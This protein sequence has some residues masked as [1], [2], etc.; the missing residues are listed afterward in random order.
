VF[1]IP[2]YQS[3]VRK[4][5]EAAAVATINAIRVAE[6]K[7]VSTT[8]TNGSCRELFEQGYLDKRMNYDSRTTAATSL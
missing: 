6:A 2:T 8:R 1:L 3:S 4:A 5:N 7:Y